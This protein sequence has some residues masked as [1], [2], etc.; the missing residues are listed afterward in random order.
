MTSS[1]PSFGQEEYISLFEADGA[2]GLPKDDS[3][4]LNQD[5]YDH[6]GADRQR[7]FEQLRREGGYLNFKQ[8]Q[9]AANRIRPWTAMVDWETCRNP[10]EMLHQEILAYVDYIS[11]TQRER[12][13]RAMVV[14]LIT[15]TIVSRWPDAIV[16]PFGSFETGLYLP[17]GD[18]DLVISSDS[19]ARVSPA[20]AL[21]W[22]ARA[23][24]DRGLAYNVQIIAKAKVPIIK[25]VTTWGG[26]KVDISLNQVNGV[27]AGKIINNFLTQLPALRP[28]VFVFKAFLSQREMN[29]VYI[30][31]L[32]S[33]SVVCMVLSFLQLHPKIRNA[34]IDPCKNLGILLLELFQYYG[35]YFHYE[36]TGISLRGGGQLFNKKA[37]GWGLAQQPR[38][39]TSI[40]SIE[41]PQDPSNDVS[42]GSYNMG[43]I[44]MTLS[45][46]HSA[47]S[48]VMFER[49]D[50]LI[51]KRQKRYVKLRNQDP[52]AD[53]DAMS[54]LG[55]IL[56]V[57]QETINHRRL[58]VE[59]YD[60]GDLH[61]AVGENFEPISDDYFPTE[62]ASPAESSLLSRLGPESSNEKHRP[63]KRRRSRSPMSREYVV[64]DS[65]DDSAWNAADEAARRRMSDTEEENGRYG[66]ESANKRRKKEP[67]SGEFI[68]VSDDSEEE[69]AA[70]KGI[71][72][73]MATSR[74]DLSVSERIAALQR[75]SSPQPG[76]RP[77]SPPGT[78]P[79]VP[80]VHGLKDKIAHFDSMGTAPRPSG[81]FGL[82][83]PPEHRTTSREL[84]GNRIP[85]VPTKGHNVSGSGK[86]LSQLSNSST[87]S[88][89]HDAIARDSPDENPNASPTTDDGSKSESKG[90]VPELRRTDSLTE[91][92]V[93]AQKSKP[94][95][96]VDLATA[97]TPGISAPPSPVP[98][99]EGSVPTG[100]TTPLTSTAI[101][102]LVASSHVPSRLGAETP[103]SMMVE[104]GS[105]VDGEQPKLVPEEPGAVPPSPVVTGM[106]LLGIS[107]N[108]ETTPTREDGEAA[109]KPD[110]TSLAPPA[111][112][113]PDEGPSTPL[114]RSVD[115]TGSVEAVSI[116]EGQQ[117]SSV[118]GLGI[119][120]GQGPSH[121]DELTA[122]N[123]HQLEADSPKLAPGLVAPSG[124][125]S[126]IVEDGSVS[127]SV[128]PS[129]N[130]ELHPGART[131][132]PPSALTPKQGLSELPGPPPGTLPLSAASLRLLGIEAGKESGR[133]GTE[134]PMSI[135]VET[136][137]NDGKPRDLE[138]VEPPIATP[139]PHSS[140]ASYF[141]ELTPDVAMQPAA[142]MNSVDSEPDNPGF[143]ERGPPVPPK[144]VTPVVT[145]I[146]IIPDPMKTP[147]NTSMRLAPMTTPTRASTTIHK[148][149]SR[150]NLSSTS[151]ASDPA[152]A[153]ATSGQ[154]LSVPNA[155]LQ[156]RATIGAAND[157]QPP[158]RRASRVPQMQLLPNGQW[159]VVDDDSDEED[160]GGWAKVTITR[161]R[162]S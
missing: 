18:I 125:S 49:N 121:G 115:V 15:N 31:G 68:W 157:K 62:L 89:D 70:D 95:I 112:H 111:T 10:S 50:Q 159:G 153:G 98:D 69:P 146:K 24:K 52:I 61:K 4:E 151:L 99:S 150:P 78:P 107:D 113:R 110:V 43:K 100:P 46:A 131:P 72:I 127:Y 32:G 122:R 133:S 56:S 85:G 77:T 126:V 129:P 148:S 38:Q 39:N 80:V 3:G 35:D 84:Y 143:S 17:L 88:F 45:G 7:A 140:A 105:L 57:S 2:D 124:P 65:D 8:N 128:L 86:A 21:N 156:R 83:A 109:T 36:R 104:T 94:G 64:N 37:R 47:L 76:G 139:T 147:T 23:L 29:E 11:P 22:I 58:V 25:F 137:S 55:S 73:S 82:G 130:P 51:A 108:G 106:Q 16:Q 48:T 135:L 154:A 44:R 96:A 155:G 114:A 14:T 145:N 74:K 142:S 53:A 63:S 118:S 33:Y 28:L 20:S 66:V 81:S 138:G 149:R 12:R 160:T 5:Q 30:G 87:S 102:N 9:H 97:A 162:W 93:D 134:T 158:R 59:L 103:V 75:G 101:R 152:N 6:R 117:T 60:S 27:S 42:K 79:K 71:S 161:S 120:T 92:W 34:E 91:H 90:S 40:L 1:A 123:V 141:E 19:I 13:T 26:F 132:E 67:R 54:I 144:N 41:D 136:G 116:G 119:S